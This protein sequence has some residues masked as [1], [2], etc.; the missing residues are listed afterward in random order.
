MKEKIAWKTLKHIHGPATRVP[1]QVETLVRGPKSGDRSDAY[2]TLHETLVGQNAW[3]EASGPAVSLLLQ[4]TLKATEPSELF[5]LVGDIIGGDQLRGWIE[6]QE[7]PTTSAEKAVR[8]AAIKH[9]DILLDALSSENG[10]VRG[11]AAMVLAMLPEIHE[12]SMPLIL[13]QAE[14]DPNEIARAA[15]LL[16]LGRLAE[17]HEKAK[18]LVIS[19]ARDAGQPPLARGAAGV[20]WLR[21]DPSRTFAEA[22]Q[23]IAGWLSYANRTELPWFKVME[24]F[25]GLDFTN[26]TSRVLVILA[27]HRGKAAIAQMMDVAFAL[28]TESHR[29]PVEI[30]ST[31][32]LFELAEFRTKP[33]K[34]HLALSVAR[35]EDLSPE[36]AALAKKLALTHVLP[37][38]G[39][40]LPASGATR[41]RWAGLEPP[42]PLE[43][44]VQTVEGGQ[45][46]QWWAWCGNFPK[47]DTF[48]SALDRWQA[49]VEYEAKSYPPYAAGM[50]AEAVIALLDVTPTTEEFFRLAEQVANDLADRSEA[51]VGT[52]LLYMLGFGPSTLLFLPFVRAGR[53][54][55]PRWDLLIYVGKE[56]LARE[57]L[58]ALPVSRREG[59]L[60]K[61]L[62]R[63]IS[64]AA[65]ANSLYVADLAPTPR[66]LEAFERQFEGWRNDN[67]LR[68]DVNKF[69]ARLADILRNLP[70]SAPDLPPKPTE[71]PEHPTPSAT[72]E[73][74]KKPKSKS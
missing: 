67:D 13:G 18:A 62:N 65:V 44:I 69:K 16:A 25:R 74:K 57:V 55:D 3:S 11:A 35:F 71:K 61:Y 63:E 37:R 27:R 60:C 42:G 40:G 32:I 9:Q 7:K 15:A 70:H 39:I 30:Q 23:E 36:Q 31:K 19:S 48:S 29:K 47:P 66:V 38:G 41:R 14:R 49:T 28:A 12:E 73:T 52:E 10:S 22:Q 24:W 5:I 45:A 53:A 64:Y 72:P 50:R 17:H 51:V 20:S 68:T 26:S 21:L 46:P 54:I 4:S 58:S 34:S 56:P 6:G 8:D 59:I 1:V 33:P 2:W 43:R